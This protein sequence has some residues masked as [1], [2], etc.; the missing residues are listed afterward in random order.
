MTYRRPTAVELE[1]AL[2]PG[3]VNAEDRGGLA[4]GARRGRRR[5][6]SGLAFRQWK[7]RLLERGAFPVD[8]CKRAAGAAR[9]HTYTPSPNPV[10]D[11]LR[12]RLYTVYGA[13]SSNIPPVH[14]FPFKVP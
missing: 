12:V 6:R 11:H 5:R 13:S 4:G 9:E 1:A 8:G 10:W 3:L 14:K 2:L 7:K